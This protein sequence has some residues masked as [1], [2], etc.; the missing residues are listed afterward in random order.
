[1]NTLEFEIHGQVLTRTDTQDVVSKNKNVYKCRFTFEEDSEWTD[2]NKFAIF[3]DGWGNSSTQHLGKNSNILSCL[4]PSKV[5]QGSYFKISIY[6]GDLETTNNISIA[7]LPTGYTQTHHSHYHHNCSHQHHNIYEESED[8]WVEIFNNLDTIID[9]I[10]YDNQ[11][12]HLFHK[13]QIIESIYLPF[14]REDEFPQL[15]EDIINH[16]YVESIGLATTENDGLL[17]SEDKRKLDSIEEGANH[18]TVD[19]ELDESSDNPVSNKVVTVALQGKEDT[20]DIVE[21]IDN[22]IVELINK[23]GE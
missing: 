22:I 3:T 18:I 7:L 12:L 5:L 9:S 6:A 17:S 11:M 16:H 8:I 23:N 4:I 15:V 1:M 2:K 14:I 10:I 21:R 13:D 19:D 20:Y